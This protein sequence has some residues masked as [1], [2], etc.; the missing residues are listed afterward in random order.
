M[1][2]KHPRQGVKILVFAGIATCLL[3]LFCL[4]PIY[5][6]NAQASSN[7]AYIT[8]IDRVVPTSPTTI[9][10]PTPIALT[11]SNQSTDYL[12]QLVSGLIGAI[13]GAVI[14]VF[15][16]IYATRRQINAIYT[17]DKANRE[18]AERKQIEAIRYSLIVEIQ[19]NLDLVNAIDRKVHLS[20]EAWSTYKG[21]IAVLSASLQEELI[22]LYAKAKQYNSV[23]EQ[24]SAMYLNKMDNEP[25]FH[26]QEG[27]GKQ[28]VDIC[29]SVLKKL[30][31]DTTTP[32]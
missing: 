15:G 26:L 14:G 19:E 10:T 8:L 17:Q 21:S 9:P 5:D 4:F 18:Y 22:M 29:H 6:C 25:L 3:I 7:T 23:L 31:E 24:V 27:L 20:T 2:R 30:A 13:F 28:L 16:T 32:Y 11:S 1:V 12:L